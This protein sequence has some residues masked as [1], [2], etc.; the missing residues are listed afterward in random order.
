[1]LELLLTQPEISQNEKDIYDQ[2]AQKLYTKFVQI[3]C[4]N[5]KDRFEIHAMIDHLPSCN[6]KYSQ[7][8]NPIK[9]L[10][11]KTKDIKEKPLSIVCY[12]CGYDYF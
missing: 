12:L 1:M 10:K 3:L 6:K 5:C 7:D 8:F 9:E 4:Q 2:V 11:D